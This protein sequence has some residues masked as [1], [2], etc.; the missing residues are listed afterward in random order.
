MFFHIYIERD[1]EEIKEAE[2]SNVSICFQN[3]RKTEKEK[4]KLLMIVI[5]LGVNKLR[6]FGYR[7]AKVSLQCYSAYHALI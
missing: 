4:E 7:T 5:V 6:V 2:E 3:K 1:R